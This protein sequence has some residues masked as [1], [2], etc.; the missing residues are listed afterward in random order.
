MAYYFH[1]K[2]ANTNADIELEAESQSDIQAVIETGRQPGSYRDRQTAKQ[3]S[4]Y[5]LCYISCFTHS[6]QTPILYVQQQQRL[7][8]AHLNKT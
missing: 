1:I 4:V 3:N 5:L 2:H 7:I 8:M 6:L